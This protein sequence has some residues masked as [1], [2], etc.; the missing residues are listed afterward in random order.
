MSAPNLVKTL[1]DLHARNIRIQPQH[2]N[3]ASSIGSECERQLVYGRVAWAER[4]RPTVEKQLNFDEGNLHER[5]IL[6][7]LQ[8]AGVVVVEQQAA[9]VEEESKISFHLDAIVIFDDIRYPLELKSC[10]PYIFD[11]IEK[12]TEH[13]FK[14]AMDELGTTY[15]W[16][17]KYPAQVLTYCK[18]KK[19]EEG[20]IVF[21]NKANGR[22]KQ[23]FINASELSEYWEAIKAKSQRVDSVVREIEIAGGF[24]TEAGSALLPARCNDSNE[25]KYCDFRFTCLP[26]VDFGAPLSFLNDTEAEEKIDRWWVLSS[27]SKEFKKLDD[28]VKLF[29]KGKANALVGKYHITGKTDKRGFWLR[30]IKVVDDKDKVDLEMESEKLL[31]AIEQKKA[32]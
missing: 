4:E 15:T 18:A 31:A 20:I 2:V 30:D 11:A 8:Q 29:C 23:F 26:D 19:L 3:R 1:Y 25:C 32:A 17:K 16:L 13:E 12:Y 21:K 14:K 7:E 9:G 27:I 28:D 6:M 22:M 24:K 10:S 5:Q